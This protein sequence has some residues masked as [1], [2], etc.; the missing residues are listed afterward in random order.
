MHLKWTQLNSTQLNSI[1]SCPMKFK[2]NA[3]DWI[4][5]WCIQRNPSQFNPMQF[6]STK[7]NSIELK[8]MKSNSIQL[9]SS[10]VK[11]MRPEPIRGQWIRFESIQCKSIQ[12][13][14]IQF[15]APQSN[16]IQFISGDPN[17]Y[18]GSCMNLYS[19]THIVLT[20]YAVCPHRMR[21]KTMRGGTTIS[22]LLA[23]TVLACTTIAFRET[24]LEAW[25]DCRNAK[26]KFLWHEVT[27][28]FPRTALIQVTLCDKHVFLQCEMARAFSNVVNIRHGPLRAYSNTY[29]YIYM[30]NKYVDEDQK[31]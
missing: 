25:L 21:H 18:S 1:Q 3:S 30:W 4:L 2:S 17:H 6:N 8:S 27:V 7:S 5:C 31:T 24:T 15:N 12:F 16:P 9:S 14:W 28:G 20:L 11:S 10:E 13:D 19:G 22:C 29:I 26:A 23:L